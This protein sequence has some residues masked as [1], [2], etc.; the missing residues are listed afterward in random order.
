MDGAE[1]VLFGYT[2]DMPRIERF[3]GA[4]DI[5]GLKGTLYCFDFQEEA[6]HRIC[7]ENVPIQCMDFE[8]VERLF[9]CD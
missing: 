7:G 5:H 3:Y 8:A 6:M 1:P 2:C 9:T 4:L